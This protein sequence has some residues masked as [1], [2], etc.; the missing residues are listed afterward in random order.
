MCWAV[1][2][3][4]VLTVTFFSFIKPIKTYTSDWQNYLALVYCIYTVHNLTSFQSCDHFFTWVTAK[5]MVESS[6]LSKT[7]GRLNVPSVSV[8]LQIPTLSPLGFPKW[9]QSMHFLHSCP[10]IQR[11]I[12]NTPDMMFISGT[13][14]KSNHPQCS[15]PPA[16]GTDQ[17]HNWM[18]SSQSKSWGLCI[19][20]VFSG[21]VFSPTWF[22]RTSPCPS[23]SVPVCLGWT[24][25]CQ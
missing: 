14:I 13:C 17:W 23:E 2:T 15:F 3:S 18:A 1:I 24:G 7:A 5:W 16:E 4:L 8:F 22:P 12:F 19:L 10:A 21:T 20:S 9:R 6:W 11:D 25:W